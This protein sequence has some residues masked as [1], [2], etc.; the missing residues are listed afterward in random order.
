MIAAAPRIV[1]GELGRASGRE[2]A[3]RRQ[4]FRHEGICDHGGERFADHG[5]DTRAQ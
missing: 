2:P 3:A 1:D 4:A 5:G